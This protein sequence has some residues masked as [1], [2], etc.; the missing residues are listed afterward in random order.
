MSLD[1]Q[2]QERVIGGQKYRVTPL[3]AIR[4]RKVFA[5]FMKLV[6]PALSEVA[7]SALGAKLKTKF[8]KPAAT[9][10]KKDDEKEIDPDAAK[11]LIRA[12]TNIVTGLTEDDVEYFCE[13]FAKS[14]TVSYEDG[15][16]PRLS[17]VF[18]LHFATKYD[19]MTA[20]LLFCFEVN[21]A[22]FFQKLGL[23]RST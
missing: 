16:T 17:D 22:G 5:R 11:A 21:F 14:T 20:W 8:T 10:E 1:S 9:E 23:N 6:S 7:N 2:A 4:G 15:K 18:A 13:V 19:E 12:L 3:D